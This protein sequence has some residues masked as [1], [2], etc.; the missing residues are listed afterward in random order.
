VTSLASR[1]S[2]TDDYD[3]YV[4]DDYSGS[5]SGYSNLVKA[6]IYGSN[7][8]DFVVGHYSG[9]PTTVYPAAVRYLA[10]TAANV[11]VDQ[12]DAEGRNG[13]YGSVWSSVVMAPHRLTDV[14]EIFLN[15]AE[16]VPMTL[17]RGSGS[18]DLAFEIFDATAGGVYAR[19]QGLA[20][21]LSANAV[22]DSVTFVAP[23][24]GWFPVV[25]YRTVGPGADTPVNYSFFW[26]PPPVDVPVLSEAG[27]FAFHGALPNPVVG[28][29]SFAF[30]VPRRE[31]VE[32]TLYDVSGRRVR[33]LVDGVLEPGRQTVAWDRRTDDGRRVS[34]GVYFA[35]LQAE[36]D[37]A[38]RRVVVLD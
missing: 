5:Q 32:L 24:A 28:V 36:D 1:G 17:V 33:R 2:S 7:Q 4:Y 16:V 22:V 12:H 34:A 18:A 19:G 21:S 13:G 29:S 35:R 30:E 37:V 6:S 8:T 27:R 23:A 14:Y 31:R 11:S 25:V 38:Q 15:P 26:G 20:S 3:I 9:T 10:S